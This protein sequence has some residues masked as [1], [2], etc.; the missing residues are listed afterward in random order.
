MM[1]FPPKYKLRNIFVMISSKL[2][3]FWV[4]INYWG[5]LAILKKELTALKKIIMGDI[6]ELDE[7]R[8]LLL[9]FQKIK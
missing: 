5:L 4:K 6:K 8:F 1:L 9:A 7:S 3:L 2:L